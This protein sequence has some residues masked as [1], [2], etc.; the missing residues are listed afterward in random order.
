M[1]T[2][3]RYILTD[4]MKPSL[5]ALFILVS[6]IWLMQSLR[7]MDLI[8]NKGL[9]ME[10]FLWITALVMPSMLLVI[11][12]I[13]LFAGSVFAFK[14]LHDEN[15][16]SPIFSTGQSKWSIVTPTLMVASFVV[17]ICFII[18][19]FI[20]P[21]GMRTFKALQHELRQSA[22]TLLIEE[23]QF[24]QLDKNMMVYIREKQ[25]DHHLEG[26]LVHNSSNEN[27]PET[28]MAKKG[29]ITFDANGYPKITLIDGTRQV[30]SNERLNVLEF[31]S[32]TLDVM[33]QF[34]KKKE[35]T[36]GS[37]ELFM[38]ELLNTDGVSEKRANEM[39]A[40]FQKRLIWPLSPIPMVLIAA[41]YLLKYRKNRYGVS[42]LVGY[43]S[44]SI[45]VYQA[46][47]MSFHNL[48][49]D[50]STLAL[51]GQWILPVGVTAL[52]WVL[53]TD[54]HK[55]KGNSYE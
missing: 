34:M 38:G 37:Q 53:L 28:W 31:K 26:I 20:M 40:E 42:K 22:G 1:K 55:Y 32:H 47:L 10:T 52:S 4:V 12:P 44:L 21:S 43:A 17:F 2:L 29:T 51:Y 11:L 19:L 45:V 48:A 14:R 27:A 49:N 35:R 24:N 6:I 5:L 9:S 33:Q 16:L 15:E 3:T 54:W 50:G 23:G 18:S 7:F 46:V 36:R 41:L 39:R 13:S 25:G 30:V 8:V